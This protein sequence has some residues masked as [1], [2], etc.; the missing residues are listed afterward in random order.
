LKFS[1]K[2]RIK[3]FLKKALDDEDKNIVNEEK[4]S[5]K[6]RKSKSKILK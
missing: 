6:N 1:K 5:K 2:Y 3:S 4:K